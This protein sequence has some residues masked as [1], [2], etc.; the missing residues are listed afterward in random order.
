MVS[1]FMR[2]GFFKDTITNLLGHE[3][4]PFLGWYLN[5]YIPYS[6]DFSSCWV[7]TALEWINCAKILGYV[8]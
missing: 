7:V 1:I 5:V 6:V 2:I 4:Y 3:Q 8:S